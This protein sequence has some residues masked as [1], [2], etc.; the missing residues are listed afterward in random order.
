MEAT[1][2]HACSPFLVMHCPSFDVLGHFA[3]GST[4]SSE[5]TVPQ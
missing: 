4:M 2:H 5:T 1:L 3:D